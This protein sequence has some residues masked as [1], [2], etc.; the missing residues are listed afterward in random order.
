MSVGDR[1]S[2]DGT[3][4][5]EDVAAVGGQSPQHHAYR[6]RLAGPVAPDDS[7]YLARADRHVPVVDG[8]EGPVDLSDAPERDGRRFAY[9]P[10]SRSRSAAV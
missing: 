2:T 4:I 3:S 10:A 7:E 1:V 8:D 5:S 6:G 9:N